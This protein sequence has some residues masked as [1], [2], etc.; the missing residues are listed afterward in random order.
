MQRVCVA[1]ET[2]IADVVAALAPQAGLGGFVSPRSSAK[3]HLDPFASPMTFAVRYEHHGKTSIEIDRKRLIRNIQELVLASP[4]YL[5]D[6]DD[7]RFVVAIHVYHDVALCSVLPDWKRLRGYSPRGVAEA[8]ARA[9]GE[10]EPAQTTSGE[11]YP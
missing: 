4:D 7:P 5:V 1:T 11:G 2:N 6:D 9:R 10:A 3:T 8:R